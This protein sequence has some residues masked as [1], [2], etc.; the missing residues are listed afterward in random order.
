MDNYYPDVVTGVQTR[1]IIRIRP[2]LE[3]EVFMGVTEDMYHDDW[4]F[5]T[6]LI[7]DAGSAKLRTIQDHLQQKRAMVRQKLDRG[8]TKDEFRI[9]EALLDA[10]DAAMEGLSLVWKNVHR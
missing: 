2:F 3:K 5:E 10:Y 1:P 9:G 6:A 8:V 7:G 4:S